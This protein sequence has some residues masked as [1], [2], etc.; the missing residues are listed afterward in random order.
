MSEHIGLLTRI[1]GEWQHAAEH[2]MDEADLVG[3]PA[4]VW[5]E[6]EPDPL[7]PQPRRM[8]DQYARARQQNAKRLS[9]PGS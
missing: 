1:R 9:P 7:M 5:L 6:D 4:D 3:N 8:N 2:L